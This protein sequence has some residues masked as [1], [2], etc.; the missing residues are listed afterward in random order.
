MDVNVY[1]TPSEFERVRK[2]DFRLGYELWHI[3]DMIAP[4]DTGNLRSAISLAKNTSSIIRLQYN[5]FTANYIHFLET[6]AGPVKKYKGFIEKDTTA[7]CLEA[8]ISYLQSGGKNLPAFVRRPIIEKRL[9]GNVFG[10]ENAILNH[11][12][13]MN[14]KVI[15]F[16][17]RRKV[18]QIR[19][20]AYRQLT[21]DRVRR[22]VGQTS[23]AGINVKMDIKDYKRLHRN[24]MSQ[25]SRIL[26]EMRRITDV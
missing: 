2:L 14:T 1:L 5:L 16:D 11:T 13:R 21:S 4:F 15:T 18:S 24:N 3:A 6:G 7:A 12:N 23:T 20:T 25:L 10:S 19:E 9:S 8:T 17:Q 26:T 22:Q